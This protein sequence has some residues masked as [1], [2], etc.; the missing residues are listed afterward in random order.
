MG[1]V[2]NAGLRGL[3]RGG[4]SAGNRRRC[5]SGH[6]GDSRAAGG[7]S[8]SAPPSQA[9]GSGVAWLSGD[10]WS[11]RIVDAETGE[12]YSGATL[13]GLNAPRPALGPGLGS[14]RGRVPA[15]IVRPPQTSP[16][17]NATG[18][19]V[20]PGGRA[21]A[22][23]PGSGR[24]HSVD[25]R[26]AGTISLWLHDR[27][28]GDDCIESDQSAPSPSGSASAFVHLVGVSG[29]GDD[30]RRTGLSLAIL[31]VALIGALVRN[32]RIRSHHRPAARC[33]GSSELTERLANA[34]DLTGSVDTGKVDDARLRAGFGRL[35]E[36]MASGL[37][38]G[39]DRPP[40][41]RPQPPGAAR[42]GSRTS[43]T[44]PTRYQRP[45]SI[46]LGRPRPLQADQRH[47]R[48]HG[49]RSPSCARSPTCSTS[50]VRG[51]D[52]VGRYGGEEFM[53]VMPET[54]AD[55]AAAQRREAAPAR[56]LARGPARRRSRPHRHAERRGRRGL[57]AVPPARRPGPRRGRRAV[58][59]QGPR[60][61]PGL[62]LPRDRRR[63]QS[64]PPRR[65]SARRLASRPS[66]W[67]ERRW[68]PRTRARS[69][70][71]RRRDRRGRAGRRR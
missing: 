6:V 43:W 63:R 54:D 19:N 46:V 65:R 40:D 37:D 36:R 64:R 50:N 29:P 48:A 35:A 26:R 58:L 60:A 44:G 18:T 55:A 56:R 68:A 9:G 11:C 1:H 47:P 45:C 3:G 2:N 5:R 52:L 13:E 16:G 4:R 59:G 21:A 23:R 49:R 10:G 12:P 8:T 25:P 53:I 67:A 62:R 61:R 33:A 31:A 30:H 17:S 39:H 71:P 34:T 41:R 66:R 28:R 70:T 32:R 24:Y 38:P 14:G 22:H 69:A 51:V 27:S 7:S 20:P 15:V 42:P 57:G